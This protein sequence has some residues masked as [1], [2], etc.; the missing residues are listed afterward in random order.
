M[1]I[2]DSEDTDVHRL[3]GIVKGRDQL[4]ETVLRGEEDWTDKNG[5]LSLIVVII[6]IVVVMM[7]KR[8]MVVVL[9]VWRK[10]SGKLVAGIV[11]I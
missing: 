5:V 4:V 6:V 2:R 1:V 10:R 8:V 11:V 9:G 3:F 7:E